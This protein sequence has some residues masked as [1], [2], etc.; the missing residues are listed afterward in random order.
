LDKTYSTKQIADLFRVH[1]NTVRLYE[2]WGF[3][4]PARRRDNNYRVFTSEHLQQ[5]RL[6]RMALPGPYP[7]PGQIVQTMVR[8]FAAGNISAA[9][10]LAREYLGRVEYEKARAVE[11]MS[12]LDKWFKQ[13][14]G[15]KN[16]LVV[17]GRRLA[18]AEIGVSVDTLRNWERNGLFSVTRNDQNQLAFS[19]WD[20]EKIRVIRLLRNCGYTISSLLRVFGDEEKLSEKPSLLLSLPNNDADFFYVT[21]LFLDY[22]DEH[23]ERAKRIMDFIRGKS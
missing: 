20:M 13:K 18:A 16:Q 11:A 4:A 15:D 5:M 7:L 14:T 1:P 10:L 23:S 2:K 12:I 9:L 22:L 21:D 8:E 3:I 19:E 6:A 17:I